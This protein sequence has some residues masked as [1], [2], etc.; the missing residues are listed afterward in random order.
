M[1]RKIAFKTLGCR[2]N[3][4]ET[5]ALVSEFRESDYD[6]VPYNRQA[7]VYVIN[8]CT[9][10]NQSDH[11]SRNYLSQALRINPSAVFLVTGCMATTQ[12]EQ[13]L[14]NNAVTYVVDNLNKNTIVSLIESHFT[15]E[16]MP[17]VL[18][19]DIFGFRPIT[20]GLHTR[21]AI[22][23]QDGCNHF[24]TYCIVP[25]VRGRATSR[26][27]NQV[28][29]D[30]KTVIDN[31]YKEIV[32]TGVN[33]GRYE[34]DGLNFEELYA[35]ILNLTGDFRVRIS[36]IEPYGLSNKF[37]DL[38][39]HPKATPHI[40]ICLQSGSDN[41]L[42]NMR[43]GYLLDDYM[44]LIDA[45]KKRYDRFNFTTDIIVGFPG[46]TDSD[47]DLTYKAVEEIGFSHVH[48]FKYSK[49]SSTKA[50]TMIDQVPEPVKNQ[51]SERIRQLADVNKLKYR[52]S[53]IGTNQL[54]LIEK[55]MKN[56]KAQGYGEHYL[57]IVIEGDK[58]EKNTFRNGLVT[59]ID[60]KSFV[61]E[62]QTIENGFLKS[63][64]L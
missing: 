63:N 34:S 28:L 52:K 1:K 21:T 38:L 16:I 29:D 14:A 40:H 41:I 4:Y 24:C 62:A 47:F 56:S 55:V 60:S 26:P 13:L 42:K 8:T 9:V 57:P 51:R 48:T 15:G 31:G 3:Q 33:I 45:I 11:K 49:R 17:P 25:F 37:V 10:T 54:V 32:L 30:I 19:G 58:P 7:D 61:L 43:R 20:K 12:K 27:P 23:I 64:Q 53:F 5:D 44:S 36:S 18:E 46:E 22:K 6:I 50:D 35:Q 59:G 2:L 39:A